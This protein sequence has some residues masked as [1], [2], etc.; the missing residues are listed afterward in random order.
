MPETY[1]WMQERMLTL[2]SWAFCNMCQRIAEK[3]LLLTREQL[4]SCQQ[5]GQIP[6]QNLCVKIRAA[7][8]YLCPFKT[9][10]LK[11]SPP[12]VFPKKWSQTSLV[13]CT[14]FVNIEIFAMEVIY[15]AFW[16]VLF[17]EKIDLYLDLFQKKVRIQPNLLFIFTDG[18]TTQVMLFE[19]KMS[20]ISYWEELRLSDLC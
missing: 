20:S 4:K 17:W 16:W 2:G 13:P 3:S 14:D 19:K 18:H 10:I 8:N 15:S 11:F 12:S 5:D 7:C 9:D 6:F 1:P